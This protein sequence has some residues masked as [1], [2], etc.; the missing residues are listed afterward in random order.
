MTKSAQYVALIAIVVS[1]LS[2]QAFAES[3]TKGSTTHANLEIQV[4]VVQVV[5]TDR[6]PNATPEA[7]VSYFI[8]TVQPRMSVTREIRKMQ[9]TKGNK[10]GMVE[11]T[12]VVAE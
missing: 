3:R 2:G 11:I 5:M 8:P 12:T 9:A 1:T 6:S 4:N 10:P 7:A